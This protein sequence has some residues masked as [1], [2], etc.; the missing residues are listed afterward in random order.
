MDTVGYIISYKTDKAAQDLENKLQREKIES[1]CRKNAL[2]LTKFITEPEDSRPDY[3][4]ELV[5]LMNRASGS[6]F[7]A[8]VVY[9]YDR[10]A[11]DE[12]IRDWI[13]EEFKKYGI[14]VYSVKE[15]SMQVSFEQSER[16][17]K[18][19]KEKVLDLPSL[20]EVVT[21]VTQLVQDPKSSAEDL[22]K[23]ISH[24]SGLTSRVLKLVNSA[25]Y[26]FPK[27][28]SSIQH[29]IM[30][31]G[32]TTIKGL[33]LS[34][35][36]FK[37]FSPKNNLVNNL[38]YK[39]F[40]KHSLLTAIASKKL[41]A[42]MFFEDDDN[43]FSAAILHDIG[44]LILDQY[45]HNNY[46]NVIK[47]TPDQIYANQVLEA[48]Q[49]YCEVTHPYIGHIVASGWNLPPVLADVIK[50]HHAPLESEEHEKITTVVYFA[51]IISQLVLDKGEFSMEAFDEEIVSHMGLD[52]EDLSNFFLKIQEEATELEDL[53]SFFK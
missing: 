37:I 52:E 29:A 40:W 36:I 42:D 26:G 45:D 30:I 24:D 15:S 23:V 49:K 21:K 18:S 5:K 46:M 47:N 25:Y 50:Y 16:K 19:I 33:V 31:L 6:K 28:I 17:S 34:S 53:E 22:G 38:D 39:Q 13:I 43:I 1:F 3:H 4:P 20:P 12:E 8:M 2:L 11:E 10:L 9:E 7:S 41:Y 48:E 14:Q 44:K 27:Q 51:N 35:S 32:F